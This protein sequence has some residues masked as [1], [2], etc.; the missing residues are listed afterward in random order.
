MF[1]NPVWSLTKSEKRAYIM[2]IMSRMEI[3]KMLETADIRDD[4][5]DKAEI[6]RNQNYVRFINKYHREKIKSRLRKS[7]MLKKAY[8]MIKRKK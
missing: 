3:Q 8:Y 2:G 1:E 4:E 5:K 7:E 6:L